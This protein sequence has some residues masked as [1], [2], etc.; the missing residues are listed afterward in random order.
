[1]TT[2][3]TAG[4][5]KSEAPGRVTC[6]DGQNELPMIEISTPWSTAELY[7]HGAH[8]TQFKKPIC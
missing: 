8:V 2:N 3:K 5:A 6:L 1:M 7:L 4:T